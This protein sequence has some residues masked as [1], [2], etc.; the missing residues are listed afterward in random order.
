[1]SILVEK[2][3][4]YSPAST[5]RV[6]EMRDFECGGHFQTG[7]LRAGKPNGGR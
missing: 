5:V 7:W 1:M 4:L 3:L 6:D 2:S